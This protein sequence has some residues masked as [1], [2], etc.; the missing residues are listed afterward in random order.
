MSETKRTPIAMTGAWIDICAVDGFDDIAGADVTIQ[1][2]GCYPIAIV[3]GGGDAPVDGEAYLI[4]NQPGI[5]VFGN[6]D[7]IWVKGDV[8]KIVVHMED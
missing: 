5:G 6:A 1:T 3:F 8:G 4:L 7:H 2:H